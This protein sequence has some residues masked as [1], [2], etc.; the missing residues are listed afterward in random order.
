MNY[1]DDEFKIRIKSW[2]E[3]GVGPDIIFWHG[4][5]R[6]FQFIRNNHVHPLYRLWFD[7][8]LHQRIALPAK[9]LVTYND[10][11][12]GVPIYY[13]HWGFCYR[14]ST[15]AHLN[16]SVPQTWSDFLELCQELK[17][18]GLSPISIGL[19]DSWVSA[20]WFD[21]LNI[22]ENG[23]AFHESLLRGEQ[24]YRSPEVN[25]VF[26]SWKYIVNRGFYNASPSLFGWKDML[27]E[28][29]SGKSGLTLVS[30]FLLS[31][32]PTHDKKDIG[33][34]RFPIKNELVEAHEEFPVDI[35]FVPTEAKHKKIAEKFL[36][37]LVSD[38]VQ[39]RLNSEIGV[40]PILSNACESDDISREI[41]AL[42]NSK[43]R[44]AQY[45]DRDIDQSLAKADI[46]VFTRFILNA[47][48]QS[49][50]SQLESN[51]KSFLS[52]KI[53]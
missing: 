46:E 16:L 24:C 42:W 47:N 50:I 38:D 22:R 6:F 53:A 18:A 5:E 36:L 32:V 1:E 29:V 33:F 23:L 45:F 52:E 30:S 35:A 14:K 11:L 40:M 41:Q 43:P 3:S 51:R 39:S 9:N 48:V 25:K 2:L 13:Y 34:F 17:S 10:Q 7:N 44:H 12:Y 20:S 21:Y 26:E 19:K 37:Y 4:G 15:F 27:N 49:A 8:N 28:V 31:Y